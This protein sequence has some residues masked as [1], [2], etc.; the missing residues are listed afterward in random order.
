MLK[1]N[2]SQKTQSGAAGAHAPP[3]HLKTFFGLLVAAGACALAML[4]KP[5]LSDVVVMSD[6]RRF[7]GTILSRHKKGL[8]IDTVVAGIRVTLKLGTQEIKSVEEK[9]VPAG[10]YDPPPAPPRVSSTTQFAD[11]Q[12]IY[13][14]VP[15]IGD[16]GRDVFA[17]GVSAALRYARTY[18]I[19]HIVFLV[20]SEGGDLDEAGAI[21][22]LLDGFDRHFTYHA[23]LRNCRGDALAV[24]IMCN[25]VNVL[26]DAL[27]GGSSQKFIEISDKRKGEE[28]QVVR[29]QIA[30]EA[31]AM[32]QRRGRR[33]MIVKAMIDPLE[34]LAAWREADGRLAFGAEPPEGL[35]KEKL[36]FDV[37]PNELLVLNRAQAI[38][39][40]LPPFHGGAPELGKLLG[41][42]GWTAESDFGHK[43]MARI[44]Q[45]HRQRAAASQA[46][47]ETKVKKNV[48][49]RETVE[50]YIEH[51]LQQAAQWSPTKESYAT[52][53][54]YSRRWHW[55]WGYGDNFGTYDTNRLTPASRRKW[56]DRTDISLYYLH[57]AL[58][59]A[60]SMKQLDAEADRLGLHPTFGKDQVDQMID[61]F[62]VKMAYLQ[63]HRKKTS[64]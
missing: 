47:Y 40:G 46:S 58:R 13:L 23:I 29:S 43:C 32:A 54:A 51:N 41:V 48:S 10:F 36:V 42:T 34:S 18:G 25:T 8:R 31:A 57:N 1:M 30:S 49:R 19:H 22:R 38:E 55:G 62:N 63:A 14:E 64:K 39:L 26:P 6:G 2:V 53:K 28:E 52:Y 24:P 44:A 50:R 35:P 27:I 20:D 15:I 7:E 33:G 45:D 5:A 9:P 56:R 37:G 4:P 21:Y 12:T 16:F 3:D 60:R 59:G 17:D 61:D 11:G